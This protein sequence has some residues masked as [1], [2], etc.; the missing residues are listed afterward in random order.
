[1]LERYS[2]ASKMFYDGKPEAVNAL[3]SHSDGVTLYRA[4]QAAHAH[5]T[6]ASHM[7]NIRKWLADPRGARI[8]RP[9][10]GGELGAR[11]PGGAALRVF[12]TR[13]A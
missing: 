12:A 10:R 6:L 13:S 8:V 11:R 3:W 5:P 1:M 7:A 9:P 2:E 4:R